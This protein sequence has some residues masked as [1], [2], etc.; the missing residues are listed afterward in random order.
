[1]A[2]IAAVSLG[3]LLYVR[4]LQRK[5]LAEPPGGAKKLKPSAGISHATVSKSATAT[6]TSKKF[7][8]VYIEGVVFTTTMTSTLPTT[9]VRMITAWT[10]RKG[11]STAVM[12]LLLELFDTFMLDL[13][14]GYSWSSILLRTCSH[15]A[16]S[17]DFPLG[18]ELF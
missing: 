5:S 11:V 17:K 9:P 4:N 15:V 14:E 8:V 10:R 18:E 6:L 12:I 7:V 16:L 13:I 2:E 3:K 1:M